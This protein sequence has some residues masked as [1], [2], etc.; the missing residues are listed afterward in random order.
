MPRQTT[1]SYRDLRVGV[2]VTVAIAIFMFVTIYITREGGLPFFGGQY[3]VYSYLKDIN[4]LKA[5]APV[6]LSGVEVGAVSRVEFAEP[7]APAAVKVTLRLRS[8]VQQRITT[9]SMVT[10][11][12]LGVL[13]EKM[14]DI[15]PGPPGG[16]AIGDGQVVPGE[17]AGD[18][19]KG[20][21][22]DASRTM[23]DIRNLA[24]DVQ[25]GKGTLGQ[26]LKREELYGKVVAFVD[27]MRELLQK[28]DR[29]DGTLGKLINDPAFYDNLNQL[30][31]GM[32]EVVEKIQRGE[33]GLGRLLNDEKLAQALNDM[34][35]NFET[36]SGRMVD[37]D[38]TVAALIKERELY[39]RLNTLSGNLNAVAARLDRGDGTAG[40][41][42]HDR[43]LYDKLNQ[44][45]GELQGLIHDIRA[46]PRKYLRIK[47]SLF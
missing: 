9:S 47:V 31:K 6:H 30:S 7:G 33:G 42:L 37:G 18:P 15:D 13:G 4:G 46:D 10:V 1:V 21:L 5:G 16:T 2:V 23:K 40:Q 25:E 36:V 45:V 24:G 3:T 14:V 41:L 19:I 17:S 35:Q 32:S 11:G 20:I 38:G 8:D 27:Q 26:I 12:S 29:T 22:A 39:D 28:M 34:I 43:Q 44:T